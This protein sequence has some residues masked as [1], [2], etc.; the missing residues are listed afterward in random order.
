MATMT[1]LGTIGIGF[2]LDTS[3]VSRGLADVH[4]QLN[5]FGAS[6]KATTSTVTDTEKA[7]TRS[8]TS[9]KALS[10]ATKETTK[11]TKHLEEATKAAREE[12]GRTLP[13]YLNAA[14][15]GAALGAGLIAVGFEST[16]MAGDYQK[17][18]TALQTGA[19]ELHAN[20]GLVSS[21][22]LKMSSDVGIGSEELSKGMYMIE[23]AGFHGADG[24][25]V[26]RVAAEG[27][28]ADLAD[29]NTISNALTTKLNAY[30]ETADNA[31]ASTNQMVEAVALGK[32]HMEEFA[33][34]LS[35]VLPVAA[36]AKISFAEVA[37]AVATMTAQGM[38]A[39]QATQDLSNTIINLESPNNV[40]I[41]EM[42]AMGLEALDVSAHL[43][44]RGLTGT[45][46]LMSQAVADHMGPDGLVIQKTFLDSKTAADDANQMM[47]AMPPVMQEIAKGFL[48]GT[49]TGKDYRK[50]LGEL[51]PEQKKLMQQFATTAEK[52]HAFNDLLR[53]GNA[54][55]QTYS[56]AMD[57]MLGGTT[58]LHVA[59]MLTGGSMATFQDNVLK[60]GEAG[61]KGGKDIAEWAII[62]QNF[63]QR[64]DESK[65]AVTAAMITIG[66]GLL[67]ILTPV[68]A[69]F[70]TGLPEAMNATGA[71]FHVLG[72]YLPFIAGTVGTI[73]AVWIAWNLAMAITRGFQMAALAIQ[74]AQ[75][76]IL[77]AGSLDAATIATMA[78]NVVLAINPVFLVVL[79][80]MA[81]IA[82]LVLVV[83]HWQQVH[84]WTTK[85]WDTVRGFVVHLASL[86]THFAA[87]HKWL[88]LLL[89]PIAPLVLAIAGIGLAIR[90]V[91]AH[92]G[93]IRAI[94]SQAIGE[95]VAIFEKL[96]RTAKPILVEFGQGLV[97]FG[98]GLLSAATFVL[99]SFGGIV[100]GVGSVLAGLWQVAGPIL[101]QL[102]DQFRFAF[103]IARVVVALELGAIVLLF[104]WLWGAIIRPILGDLVET[105]KTAWSVLSWVYSNIIVPV[106]TAIGSMFGWLWD[107][108]IRPFLL[109][110]QLEFQT[111]WAILSWV[112]SNVV[113][114]VLG[115][116]GASF[117]WLYSSVL[118][119]ILS[120]VASTIGSAF[121]TLKW[122]GDNVVAPG[123]HV[124]AEA[125]QW[126]W[127]Q[128]QGPIAAIGNAVG[129]IFDSLGSGLQGT[130]AWVVDQ[131]NKL[132]KAYNDSVGK[133]PGAKVDLINQAATTPGPGGLA[134]S[135]GRFATGGVF[136]EA[137]VIVG[138]GKGREWV[139]PE[140]PAYHDRALSL[141]TDAGKALGIVSGTP[142]ERH[143]SSGTAR[144][145]SGGVIPAAYAS[146]ASGGDS[147][148]LAE[149][150]AQSASLRTLERKLLGQLTVV[151]QGREVSPADLLRQASFAAGARAV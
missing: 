44:E 129:H 131:L 9:H 97:A 54:P 74:F 43:G 117:Q 64:M 134:S 89:I 125:F 137:T 104:Q 114:P 118:S 136:S 112:Y 31:T 124:I 108:V 61:K 10:N 62:Q 123:V 93:Q 142:G 91:I 127:G 56:G 1:N 102:G 111:A 25:K 103:R 83:T 24:L 15:A 4:T 75:G 58:G 13:S 42:K 63:N 66:G 144:M 143:G 99:A 2:S 126:L 17:S 48:A 94:A 52:S 22:M 85:T 115:A 46:K 132:L 65:A 133:L 86:V 47:K 23:S 29:M 73:A 68:M 139:I 148:M 39:Q 105:M 16:K 122:V 28:K 40:A 18:I 135:S 8:S 55:A 116:I 92:F 145:A 59:L 120:F 98:H 19:G 51:N 87:T 150:K 113:V 12:M 30:H 72:G 71:A 138:E 70:A 80:I 45:L 53:A 88:A 100:A 33:G 107:T 106:G 6:T 82:V 21:G 32:M 41:K 81:L 149:L 84:S 79:G 27:S 57:K 11:E 140:D 67:P 78:W 128:I 90:F 7:I 110:L 14:T 5:L 3:P 151:N 119:P 38:S 49:E 146:A 95:V 141:W 37:G 60:I 69:A 36:A 147:E 26:L 121:G 96:W 77:I 101:Q 76:L 34:S 109:G 35:A 50:Q 20:L 130:I